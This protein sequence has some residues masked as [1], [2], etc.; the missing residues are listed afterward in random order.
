MGLVIGKTCQVPSSFTFWMGCHMTVS[1]GG[2]ETSIYD[3]AILAPIIGS[4]IDQSLA[5]IERN[6]ARE[7]VTVNRINY[8]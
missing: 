2:N 4:K 1:G 6:V 5:M 3:I 8:D 7:G